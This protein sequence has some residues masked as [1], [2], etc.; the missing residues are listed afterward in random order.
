MIGGKATIQRRSLAHVEKK[1]QT[2]G[3]LDL[4]T[5]WNAVAYMH[6][7]AVRLCFAR[8]C[9]IEPL[10][11]RQGISAH[12]AYFARRC[13]TKLRPRQEHA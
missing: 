8:S 5:R 4:V 10:G 11:K 13:M 7:L 1:L 12:A 6:A 2:A 9:T 3:V